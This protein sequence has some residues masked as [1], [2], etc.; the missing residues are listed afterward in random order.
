MEAFVPRQVYPSLSSIPRSYY[1]GHHA[2]GL[3][4]MKAMVSQIDLVVECR[5]YRTPI[6]SRNPLFEAHLGERPR[7]I[8]YTKQD[9]GSNFTSDD[10]KRE[11][12]IKK[13][14]APSTSFFT[15]IK[16]RGTINRVL[17][18]ARAHA[19]AS[20]SLFGTRLMVVGMP[21]VGKS[22]L[23]NAL[24]NVSLGKK[25]AARTG[26]Q[27][28]VTRKIGTSVKIIEGKDGNEGVYVVDTPGVFVPY[29][30]DAESMLKLA[31]CGSVKDAIIPPTTIADYLLFHL[32][33]HDP[34]LY[35]TFSEATNDIFVVL[36]GLARKQGRLKKGGVPDFE[37]SALQFVQRWRNGQMGR[38]L[39]DEV[40]E[41]ALYQRTEQLNLL[42][43]SMNQARKAVK[44]S[45]KEAY[46]D[47]G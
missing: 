23:L 36:E 18:F 41:A 31:L 19:N 11:S 6:V 13:W 34:E 30:P 32:N 35:R 1:L 20:T 9:L 24:R 44:Q 46:V 42:G 25:K 27:P 8:V 15:D 29:V 47:R 38:F 45:R 14:D 22:S 40:T 12:V 2:A 43:G 16:S 4:K 10:R 21:N 3:S 26:D 17:D 5:D 28:G 39:L 33:L 7:L 37:S